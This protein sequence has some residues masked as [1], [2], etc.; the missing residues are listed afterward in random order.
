MLPENLNKSSKIKIVRAT[1]AGLFFIDECE[2]DENK[3]TRMIV[4]N[5]KNII[6]KPDATI[7]FD[8]GIFNYVKE[9]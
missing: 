9:N 5:N 1:S 4:N 8:Y 3:L 6:K 2:E 7:Q